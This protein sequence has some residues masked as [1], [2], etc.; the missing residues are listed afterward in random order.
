MGSFILSFRLS[1]CNIEREIMKKTAIY[2]RVSSDKQAQEGDSI[3]AQRQALTKYVDDRPD[4]VLAGEYI[5][6][7]IS[8][9]KYSQRD[10]LQRL[11][12]D[13]KA[14][15]VDHIAFTKIDRW[16]RSVRHYT[17][18]QEILD[19]HGVSWTAIWEP[20]YDTTTPQGRLIVN[21]MMSIAQFEAE[22]TGQRIRQVQAY[23]VTQ[24]EVISGNAPY[25]YRIENKHL[26]PS[27]TAENVLLAF[28]TFERTGSL[29]GSLAELSGVPGIPAIKKD[30]KKM[31]MNTIYLGRYRGNNSFCVP[32]V[33]EE[34]WERVQTL[35]P[36]N[37]KT[38]QKYPYIFSGLIRCAECGCS[39]GSNTRRRQRTKNGNISITHQ[40]R[41]PKH[42]QRKSGKC[43]NAKVVAE[44]VLE[45]YLMENLSGMIS[46]TVVDYE[47][48]ARPARDNSAKIAKLRSRE[49]KLRELFLNDLISIEEYKT[50]KERIMAQIEALHNEQVEAPS[51][52]TEALRQLQ[53]MDFRSIYEGMEPEE[54]R[55]FW[56]AIIKVIWFSA[57]REIRVEFL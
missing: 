48:K 46:Q 5:D 22:N 13:V 12:E 41:C 24:G 51:I 39:F 15:K 7:G 50:E 43:I 11:L 27:E 53:G 2:I 20:I 52:N 19:R 29:Y 3:A 16:F 4:L 23:K 38:N 35:I 54:K 55:R 26:V 6:D 37:I 30:F 47:E 17:A 36:I 45:R 8:G 31:L 1:F 21:Q 25:G 32:I 57:D 9:T 42:Y 10:E 34:L 18:T 28:K 44:S 33:P 14:G 49:S 40:Y 56:R